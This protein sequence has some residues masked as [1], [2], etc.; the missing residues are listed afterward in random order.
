MTKKILIPL[1][2]SILSEEALHYVEE[3]IIFF[4]VEEKVEIILLQVIGPLLHHSVLDKDGQPYTE[5]EM[6]PAKQE[7]LTYLHEVGEK[8]KNRGVAINYEV[9]VRRTGISSAEEILR[10]ERERQVD[11]IVM[12]THGRRG[13]TRW[14]LGSVTEKILRSGRAPV[15][16]M[17][18]KNET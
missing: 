4:T 7:A 1:D 8:L 13:L 10:I 15:L 6:D 11:L 18:P 2:G 3:L 16:V 9:V 12:S 14:A 5:E 17:R